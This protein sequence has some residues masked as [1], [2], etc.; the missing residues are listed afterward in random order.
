MSR[1]RVLITVLVFL[2]IGIGIYF[3]LISPR[4][5]K[6]PSEIGRSTPQP[7]LTSG[8][9]LRT[10]PAPSPPQFPNPSA[11]KDDEENTNSIAALV[12]VFR[13][14]L[15][16]YGLVVDE[17]GDPVP[18]ATVRYSANNNPNPTGEG[19]K[20][21]TT[22]DNRGVFSIDTSG[23]GIFVRVS[24]DGYYEIPTSE[25]HRIGS[26]AGFSNADKVGRSDHA[27]PSSN[28]PA[29]FTLRKKGQASRL[30][31]VTER[32]IKIPKNGAPVNI[33]LTT[34]RVA[35][36]GALKVECWTQDDARDSQGHY[37]WRCRISVPGGGLI[38]RE[39]AFAFEAPRDG[40]QSFDDIAP[41][42]DRWSPDREQQY[43][44]KTADNHF[45][46]LNVSI[47]AGGDHFV[48]IDSYFNPQAGARNLEY[49][50]S[51]QTR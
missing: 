21:T 41:R 17:K 3:F 39:D 44:V 29:I 47:V 38:K 45:A 9:V 20:G 50:A 1:R 7:S 37:P 18:G 24:K 22:T 42:Q 6:S 46:R 2:L 19:T 23:I 33:D 28:S 13:K 43:F 25:S 26:S 40:Y 34:G 8:G 48:T 14:P 27:I 5:L 31:R 4:T 32:P 51:E 10:G 15:S 35:A 30:I 12:T 16:F 11:S 36:E 49:D